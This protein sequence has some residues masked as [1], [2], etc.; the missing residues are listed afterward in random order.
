MKGATGML[1]LVVGF[2]VVSIHAP[3]KG[4][5]CSACAMPLAYGRFNP[6]AREGRDMRQGAMTPRR[7]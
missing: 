6:R 7:S 4:A 5:T 3:V 2:G 1:A